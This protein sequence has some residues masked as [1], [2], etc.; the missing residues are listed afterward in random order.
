[1][2]ISILQI[3]MLVGAVQGF[4]FSGFAFFSKKYKSKSNFFLGM[5][6]LTFS[7][8]IFQ[9]YLIINDFFDE[10]HT[11]GFFHIPLSSV[12]LVFYYLYVY[13]FLNPQE[14]IIKQHYLLFIPFAIAF[15]ESFIEKSGFALDLFKPQQTIYFHYFRI[16]FEIFNVIYSF[17][18]I[19]LSFQLIFKFEKEQSVNGLKKIKIKLKWLKII[20][21]ILLVL[22]LYWPVPLYFEAQIR[23]DI[24]QIYFYALWIG[25]TS[26][27]NCSG[28]K[29]YSSFF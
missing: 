19:L 6:I 10:E 21:L 11:F 8:N 4:I 1:M 13:Y 5:L 23:L 27:W 7:Y 25:L 24:S 22:C 2:L 18:L 17:I 16:G 29:K 14:K 12:F 15:L 9:N 20:T 28:T 26:I 3:I